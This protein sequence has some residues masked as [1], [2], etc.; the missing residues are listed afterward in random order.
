MIGI[1]IR[2]ILYGKH[3]SQTLHAEM[4]MNMTLRI[5]WNCLIMF[6]RQKVLPD[7]INLTKVDVVAPDETLAVLFRS[8]VWG[9]EQI[10]DLKEQTDAESCMILS[11]RM[12][13]I[14]S[15]QYTNY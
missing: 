15:L 5:L 2:K 4:V 6:M 12:D 9:S 3:E 1:I 14:L 11:N 10:S 8:P 13:L 7:L